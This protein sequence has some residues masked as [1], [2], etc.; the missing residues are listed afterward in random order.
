MEQ[1]AS[2]LHIGHLKNV[3]I[4]ARHGIASI[5]AKLPAQEGKSAY[6]SLG[7]VE[8]FLV[9]FEAVNAQMQQGQ[10][11]TQQQALNNADDSFEVHTIKIE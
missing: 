4:L 11:P 7:E 3:L 9:Q 2:Q 6:D 1:Q 8:K 5:G 10:M